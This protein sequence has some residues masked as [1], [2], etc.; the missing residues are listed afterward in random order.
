[1]GRQSNL[2]PD[3]RRGPAGI[4]VSDDRVNWSLHSWATPA[5]MDDRDVILFPLM[6]PE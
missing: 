1:M 4:A 5:D 3:Q 6:R 2:Q